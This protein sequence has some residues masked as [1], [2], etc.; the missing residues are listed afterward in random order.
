M[1]SFILDAETAEIIARYVREVREEKV[2]AAWADV[3]YDHA[4]LQD[5]LI[6]LHAIG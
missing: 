6:L 2:R 3:S 5:R 1:T 4:G